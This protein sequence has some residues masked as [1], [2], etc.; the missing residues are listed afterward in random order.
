MA[1]A[2]L[3][4]PLGLGIIGYVRDLL[5]DAPS[6][7]LVIEWQS[8]TPRDIAGAFFYLGVLALIAAFAVAR[9]RPTITD[10]LLVCG[11]AWQ[12]FVGVRYVVWFGMAAMP[13]VAQSLAAAR[14]AL[15]PAQAPSR[16]ARGGTFA[17]LVVAEL[18]LAIVVAL[19]PWTKPYLGLPAAY[20]G[21]FAPV[22]GAP[23]LFSSDTPVAA[24]AQ[25]RAE[26]CAGRI[27]NEMGYGSYM[28][29]ALYPGAQHYIDPRVELFDL[30][31]WERYA[32]VSKGQ[33]VP[34]FLDQQQVA[35]VVLDTAKQSG[36]ASALP[37][38]E[39]WERT[40][41]AGRS[42]IWRRSNR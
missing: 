40:L 5:A 13:I 6:Q 30:A 2:V 28:A 35:C 25:L 9:R 26:P 18:L 14:P 36:L 27:F 7:R 11:L 20:Q 15:A 38:L 42:E 41:S 29:W 19:Q 8:P 16:R 3:I 32:A 4:N 33:G 21:L 12:A 17:N 22:P 10:V 1:A 37:S 23:Q 24:V 34:A 31:I 39:G